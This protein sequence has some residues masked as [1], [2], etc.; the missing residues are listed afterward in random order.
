MKAVYTVIERG[1]SKPY[2]LRLGVGFVNRDG[3][4]T[5]KLDAMPV[6]GTLQ[7]REWEVREEGT[8]KTTEEGP[9]KTR[10]RRDEPQARRAHDLGDGPA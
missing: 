7:V 8:R 2:W 3:S 6:N 10:P 5:L 9:A 1:S 4:L